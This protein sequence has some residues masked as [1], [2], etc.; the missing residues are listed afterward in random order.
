[1]L[2]L[3]QVAFHAKTYQ[4][5]IQKQKELKEAAQGFGLKC[6]E[7]WGSLDLNT[8]S[9]K[10]VQQSLFEDLK[11]SY[12]TLPK[13]GMMRNGNVYQVQTLGFNSD[14]KDYILLPT[15]TKSDRKGS[16]RN[17]W[18]L[19]NHHSNLCEWLRD[20]EQDGIYPHPELLEAL[21]MYPIRYTELKD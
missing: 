17:R 21:M 20:G 13:S 10:T 19:N 14:V 1:M 4:L 12:A 6:L 5:L 2:T 8:S 9:L 11:G 3:S 18:Y 7:L 16:T 15:P